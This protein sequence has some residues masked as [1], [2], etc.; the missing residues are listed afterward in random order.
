MLISIKRICLFLFICPFFLFAQ[1]QKKT[2]LVIPLSKNNIRLSSLTER[3]IKY[4]NMSHDSVINYIV[5]TVHS[6]MQNTFKDYSTRYLKEFTSTEEFPDS[7]YNLKLF[8]CFYYDSKD[9]S[10]K[11]IKYKSFYLESYHNNY[12]GYDLNHDG[13]KILKNAITSSKCDYV[14]FISKFEII[15]P[16]SAFSLHV[17]ITDHALN[18]IYGNK[19]EMKKD[20]SKTMYGDVLKYYIKSSCNDM[21]KKAERYLKTRE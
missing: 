3:N 17:E 9:S 10:L 7:L 18:R 19:N 15:N 16:N 1:E 12:Y 8:N 2:L 21:L 13:L 14:L 5:N 6:E 4:N 11:N 20:I